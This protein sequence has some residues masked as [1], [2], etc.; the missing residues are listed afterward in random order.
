MRGV[1][2]AERAVFVDL[3]SVGIVLLILI[4]VVIP[5]L[6]FGARQR[7]SRSVS[8]CHL[9]FTS[10]KINTPPRGAN[11]FYYKFIFLSTIFTIFFRFV[12]I[13][14]LEIIKINLRGRVR[15]AIF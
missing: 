3:Y 10:Q 4:F 6:A 5:L 2:F 13:I 14:S 11:L 9:S 1:L 12:P 15:G 8:F 7:N